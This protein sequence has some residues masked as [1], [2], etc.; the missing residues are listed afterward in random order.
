MNKITFS[1]TDKVPFTLL[2]AKN[3]QEDFIEPVL[4][5]NEQTQKIECKADDLKIYWKTKTGLFDQDSVHG[6]K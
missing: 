4:I 2:H 5:Y 1:K 6:D 3:G